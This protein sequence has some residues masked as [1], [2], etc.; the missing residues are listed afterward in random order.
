[1]KELLEKVLDTI[2]HYKTYHNWYCYGNV[3][4]HDTYVSFE[5]Y[6]HSDQGEGADWTECWSIDSAGKIYSEDTVWNCFEDFL[7]EWT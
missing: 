3:E 5:V 6:G 1:M 7:T 4:E 2:Y